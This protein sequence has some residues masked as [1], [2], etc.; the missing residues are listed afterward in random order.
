MGFF[1]ITTGN[2]TTTKEN[3]RVTRGIYPI[4][5]KPIDCGRFLTY[6]G[7]GMASTSWVSLLSAMVFIVPMSILVVLDEST[8]P[9]KHGN[10]YP[11]YM[12]KAPRCLG[13]PTSRRNEYYVHSQTQETETMKT[14]SFRRRCSPRRPQGSRTPTWSSMRDWDTTP[15]SASGSMKI[16]WLFLSRGLKRSARSCAA[17]AG[18]QRA[19][20]SQ[21]PA[22]QGDEVHHRR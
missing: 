17:R 9:G 13:I 15:L 7:I 14:F 12:N 5:R 6:T 19:L 11:E 2:F 16:S 8:C 22:C 1:T 18:I 21:E 3:K 20:N 4:S 10:A